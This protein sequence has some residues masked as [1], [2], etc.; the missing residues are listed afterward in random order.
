MR[1]LIKARLPI[2]TREPLAG[3]PRLRRVVGDILDKN[4]VEAL[5]FGSE[6]GRHCIFFVV[7]IAEPTRLAR[8]T[9]PL[10]DVLSAQVDFMPA[11][12]PK[13][14]PPTAW[15]NRAAS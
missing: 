15:G 1:F 2:D 3:N 12:D 5:F 14:I 4:R 13:E 8:I 6:A 11:S 9:D 10:H 7:N